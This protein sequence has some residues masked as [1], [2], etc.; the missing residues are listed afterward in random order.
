MSGSAA[1]PRA[2]FVFSYAYGS[3]I[4]PVCYPNG[5]CIYP[6]LGT[7]G[8]CSAPGQPLLLPLYYV[9]SAAILHWV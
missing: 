5:T 6:P 2:P 4:A 7:G 9:L 8:T 1:A 3:A